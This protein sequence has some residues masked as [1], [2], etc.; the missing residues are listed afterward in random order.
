MLV[1]LLLAASL[2]SALTGHS[3]MAGH[4]RVVAGVRI[5]R[6]LMSADLAYAGD[7][8]GGGAGGASGGGS[9]RGSDGDDSERSV[10]QVLSDGGFSREA[11][12]E[13]VAA[14]LASGQLSAEALA[15]YLR[16]LRNP[17]LRALAGTGTFLRDRL[18][19][20]PHLAT[21]IGVETAVGLATMMIAECNARAGRMLAE[22]DFVLCDLALVVATNI[23][24]V[25][26]LSPVAQIG[27]PATK[28]LA[29]VLAKLPSS[30]MQ[31]GAFT[32]AQRIG[33]YL[34]NA[35]QFGVI[36]VAS[37][38][39]GAGATKGLVALRERMTG[40]RPDVELAPVHSTAFAYGTFVGTS[41][42]TRY[43][44]VNAIEA[45]V[46]PRLPIPTGAL[47]TAVRT[48]NNYLGGIMWIWWARLLG[49][50]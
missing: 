24:L 5:A 20:S 35:V 1:H 47:S 13:D 27:A 8:D 4:S 42:S 45:S 7:G 25:V 29:G 12:P 28:G 50:Q 39:L 19:A 21:V 16:V 3:R 31:P 36:G 22:A 44:L 6:P 37:S 38:T 41:S 10:E 15:N 9:W 11:L 17:L 18:I 2:G 33:C 48:G 43:Q 32:P 14:A 46:F 23:A 34:S 49:V 26:T 40:K 30:F